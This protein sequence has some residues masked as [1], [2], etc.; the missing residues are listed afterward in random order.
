MLDLKL[1][2][3][4]P[5]FELQADFIAP[6][7]G[8]TALFGHS[9]CGKTSILRAIAG[10]D[11][12]S[13]S[14]ITFNQQTWQ[15][16]NAF[17]ASHKRN[18]AYVFQDSLLF[19][20]LDV[21]GNIRFGESKTNGALKLE[22]IL[23]LLEIAP[24]LSKPVETLSGGEK[25]RI[26]IARALA[27]GPQLLL[28]DEPLTALDGQAKL[29]LLSI[30]QTLQERLA[31]PILY[32]SHSVPEVARL[33]D[34]LVYL[35]EGGVEAT[36][37]V[38]DL[39]TDLKLPLAHAA[40]AGAMLTASTAGHSAGLLFLDTTIGQLLI[41]TPTAPK[42]GELRLHIAARDVSVALSKPDDSSILNILQAT[43]TGITQEP[44][45]QAL[46][47]LHAKTGH[48]LAQI[49]QTSLERLS[50][51]LGANIYAQ[52]KGVALFP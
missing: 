11:K 4:Y 47:Q 34:H 2:I 22:E 40:E 36:G 48:L 41:P 32:V 33:A 29:K 30:L 20:H 16:S 9:G 10:L 21:M 25:Q 50:L 27:S 35:N 7:N 39:L 46:L 1:A 3:K 45:G 23:D 31:I 44:N 5:G 43:I 49:S 52:I 12:H 51:K 8:V 37:K 14:R 38:A 19:P 26:A 6:S 13:N 17:V 42:T 28:M 24:L 15:S 18:V